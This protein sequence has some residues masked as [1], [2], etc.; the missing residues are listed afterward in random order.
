MFGI[1]TLHQT[2]NFTGK[3]FVPLTVDKQ[4]EWKIIDASIKNI[5]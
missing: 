2:I 1:Q 4:I 5:L 3:V